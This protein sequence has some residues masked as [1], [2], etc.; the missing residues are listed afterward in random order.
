MVFQSGEEPK[1]LSTLQTDLFRSPSPLPE[2]CSTRLGYARISHGGL[3]DT[4][5]QVGKFRLPEYSGEPDNEKLTY[6]PEDVPTWT[7]FPAL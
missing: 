2:Y 3:T 7:H 6:N 4:E 1:D 5:L